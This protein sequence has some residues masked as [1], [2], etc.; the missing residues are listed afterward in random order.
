M[1]FYNFIGLILLSC[2]ACSYENKNNMK[3]DN[4]IDYLSIKI[5]EKTF[6]PDEN[7]PADW[8]NIGLLKHLDKIYFILYNTETSELNFFDYETTKFLKKQKLPF[9]ADGFAI[10]R[11]NKIHFYDYYRGIIYE[12]TNLDSCYVKYRLPITNKQNT[13][14]RVNLFNGVYSYKNSFYMAIY[15]LGEN[16]T[17]KRYTNFC[18]DI[19]INRINYDFEYP[20]EYLKA[21]W[22]GGIYR[23]GYSCFN[24][25]CNKILYS[26]PAL[27]TLEI[28]DCN[29]H[30]RESVYAGSKYIKSIKS[31]SK[32]KT[33][34]ATNEEQF[35]YFLENNSYSMITFD[36]YRNCYYRIGELST[37]QTSESFLKQYSIIILDDNLNKIGEC[38]LPWRLGSTILVSPEG[39]LIPYISQN[40]DDREPM[41]FYIFKFQQ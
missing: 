7:T 8:R 33:R 34:E 35:N 32:N 13:P 12:Y 3:E 21:N 9:R 19:E 36:P 22:G 20:A 27:H 24:K 11:D 5:G 31:F 10:A 16:E 41:K 6:F 14:T 26:F 17:I 23:I 25:E 39:V 30:K 18:I 38:L 2:W 15:T 40:K 37:D 28:Y 1:K 29:T 4:S